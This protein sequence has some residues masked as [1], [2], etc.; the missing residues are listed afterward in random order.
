MIG[1]LEIEERKP[2]VGTLL[3]SDLSTLT[4][5]QNAPPRWKRPGRHNWVQ[6]LHYQLL[7]QTANEASTEGSATAG[8]W[9]DRVLQQHLAKVT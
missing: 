2:Q 6:N 1:W 8:Y 7:M 9:R 3:R 5:Q 4:V